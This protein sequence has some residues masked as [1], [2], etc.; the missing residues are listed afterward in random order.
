LPLAT[1]ERYSFADHLH[2]FGPDALGRSSPLSFVDASDYCLQFARSHSE[3]FPVLSFAVPSSIRRD[4]AHVY[5]FC[6][7]A[8]DLADEIGNPAQS[9]RLLEW[10]REEIDRLYARQPRHPVFVA[11]LPTV[12][13]FTIP[14]QPFIDLVSA[15]RQDQTQTRYES[16][17]ELL[18]YCRRSANPVGRLVLYLFR[19]YTLER[20]ALSDALCTGL[21]LANFC[22]DVAVDYAE[23]GRIY[24]PRL[25]RAAFGVHEEDL[26]AQRSTPNARRLIEMSARRAEQYLHDGLSLVERLRGRA[27]LCVA[28]FGEGGLAI[29]R[30]IRH[31][32]Y[33]VLTSRPTLD[34]LDRVGLVAR[35][36]KHWAWPTRA[37]RPRADFSQFPGPSE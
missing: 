23:R 6:R 33:N 25:E 21:Q 30:R 37:R 8:D 16:F 31:V 3:N 2:R 7:W 1:V 14:A 29:L 17:D 24:L 4:F 12:E 35:A 13:R 32:D 10:W 9:L 18:D 20:S 22:Q 11:L 27:A 28:L 19:A 34:T 15:F 36:L 5:A 26:A